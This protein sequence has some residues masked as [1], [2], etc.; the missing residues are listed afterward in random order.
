MISELERRYTRLL[1]FYGRRRP[2]NSLLVRIKQEIERRSDIIQP[3]LRPDAKLCL[4]VLYDFMI[5]R[6][7]A[8]EFPLPFF[9]SH[10]E[11]RPRWEPFL[12]N[13]EE[14]IIRSVATIFEYLGEVRAKRNFTSD[15]YEEGDNRYSSHEILQ[16]I[17]AAWG[18]LKRP[19][20]WG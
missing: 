12:L 18:E 5:V 16:A 14:P 19:F 1:R 3:T 11:Q 2:D 10:G 15:E 7:Y 20:K 8:G 4:L 17:D 6:P 9:Q 13:A